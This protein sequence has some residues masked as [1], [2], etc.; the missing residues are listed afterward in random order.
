MSHMV[1]AKCVQLHVCLIGHSW[2]PLDTPQ[3]CY[4]SLSRRNRLS[5]QLLSHEMSPSFASLA[6]LSAVLLADS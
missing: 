4:F 1:T 5:P 2:G 3:T 6:F